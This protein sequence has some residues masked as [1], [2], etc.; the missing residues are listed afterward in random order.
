MLENTWQELEKVPFFTELVK[1]SFSIWKLYKK[2]LKIH[3]L[4]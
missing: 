3:P 1:L 4:L 2:E